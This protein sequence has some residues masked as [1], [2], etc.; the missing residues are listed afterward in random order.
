MESKEVSFDQ[1]NAFALSPQQKRAWLVDSYNNINVVQFTLNINGF[2]D[3]PKL[4][5]AFSSL[6]EQHEILRSIYQRVKGVFFPFQIITNS[7]SPKLDIQDFSTL[8]LPDRTDAIKKITSACLSRKYDLNEGPFLHPVLLKYSEKEYK[9][10]VSMPSICADASSAA[11]IVDEIVKAYRHL[12][13]KVEK[14]EDAIQYADVAQWLTDILDSVDEAGASFWTQQNINDFYSASIPCKRNAVE[15]KFSPEFYT[16]HSK[17]GVYEELKSLSE[18]TGVS[19]QDCVFTCWQLLISRLTNSDSAVIGTNFNGRKFEE[20]ASAVGL[21]DKILPV[22]TEILDGTSYIKQVEK[23]HQIL[24]G[25]QEFLE[26]YN[27]AEQSDSGVIQVIKYPVGFD[28]RMVE[29]V[30]EINGTIFE[31]ENIRSILEPFE[32]KL[33]CLESKGKLIFDLEY[34]SNQFSKVRMEVLSDQFQT[35]LSHVLKYPNLEVKKLQ[36]ASDQEKEK[37]ITKFNNLYVD[38]D[39]FSLIHQYI[40][41]YANLTPAS[42]A[43]ADENV[44]LSYLELNTMAN[45]MARHLMSLGIKSGDNIGILFQPSADMV[46]GMLAISK[47]G[48]AYVPI[49]PSFPVDRVNYIATSADLKIIIVQTELVDSLGDIKTSKLKFD[50]NDFKYDHFNDSNLNL[51][52]SINQVVYIIYTSGSTGNPK[53][54]AVSHRALSNY[55][56]G[57]LSLLDLDA[58]AEIAAFSAFASD[59]GNTALFGALCSGRVLRIFSKNLSMDAERLAESIARRPLDCL[60]IVPSHLAALLTVE[61]PKRI[62]P[63]V[64]LILGGESTDAGLIRKIK[65][66]APECRV[67]NHYG[68]TETTVGATCHKLDETNDYISL[69]IGKPINNVQAYI[70]GSS[71]DVASIGEIGELYIGGQGLAHGYWNQAGITAERFVPNPFAKREGERL[72]KTGDLARFNEDG[73]IEFLGRADFQVKIRGYRVELAEIERCLLAIPD[74]QEALV[75][76][77]NNVEPPRLIAHVASSVQTKDFEHHILA[78]LQKVIPGYMIPNLICFYKSFPRTINGKVDRKELNKTASLKD[79]GKAYIP[80][81]TEAQIKIAEL[82]KS[83][84]NIEKI[85]LNDN[86]FDLGGHSLA[87]VYLINKCRQLFSCQLTIDD[88]FNNPTLGGFADVIEV[89]RAEANA[90][91]LG[92]NM[93]LIR[94]SDVPKSLFFILPRKNDHVIEELRKNLD[95]DGSVYGFQI[96]D[97]VLGKMDKKTYAKTVLGMTAFYMH[98]IRMFQ[99]EGTYLLG[100]YAIGRSVAYE[101][102]KQLGENQQK[103]ELFEIPDELYETLIDTEIKNVGEDESILIKKN[104]KNCLVQLKKPKNDRN[105]ILISPLGVLTCYD[106]LMDHLDFDGG[107]YGF[108]DPSIARGTKPKFS[109]VEELANLYLQELL[110]VQP[111]GPYFMA[112]ASIG[113]CIA[114]EMA[115]MLEARSEKVQFLGFLDS[116]FARLIDPDLSKLGDL[117]RKM[118]T[119]LEGS[120]ISAHM[121]STLNNA[122]IRSGKMKWSDRFHMVT[123]LANLVHRPTAQVEQIHYFCAMDCEVTRLKNKLENAQSLSR[124]PIVR[125]NINTTHHHI[126]VELLNVY[127]IGDIFSRELNRDIV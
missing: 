114:Y 48:A 23:N 118:V 5:L 119:G 66:L 93:V 16:L 25:Y 28:Y 77:D 63:R 115:V 13:Q 127:E 121:E 39:G 7:V 82:W 85:G 104:S 80:P 46:V 54:V 107:I 12:P 11:L 60:K 126:L 110:K 17:D 62:L 30:Y 100:G 68:P 47:I 108:Q 52:L 98:E 125:Y 75:T 72:Y 57:V 103:A 9:L 79:N 111:K 69:P 10:L 74:V 123:S 122:E 99:T 18:S 53:G 97:I 29:S 50:L 42:T 94:K 86:F 106:M 55:V 8:S 26:Y 71:G 40:E 109:T 112:G 21:L 6:V 14:D 67:I 15:Q 61:N 51:N 116:I 38:E 22:S 120:D 49:D 43:V 31:L 96:P 32:V 56:N 58:R 92:P 90:L 34:D 65:D 87:T 27:W 117:E 113:G 24:K 35:L 4:E 83:Q 1:S 45:K 2:L 64:C 78:S 19:V 33:S 3:V 88:V 84:L 102:Y 20:L 37:I 73:S 36:L 101:I 124:K 59:L 81:E 41:K 105:L 95:F 76:Y 44:E 70:L 89:K 91:G